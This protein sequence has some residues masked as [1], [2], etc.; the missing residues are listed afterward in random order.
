[1]GFEI[2]KCES[3]NFVLL[4]QDYFGYLEALEFYMNLKIGF[5][6]SAEKSLWNFDR[7]CTDSVDH[8]GNY[9]HLNNKK[10]PQPLQQMVLGKLLSNIQKNETGLLSYT[11]Q[12]NKFK[13]D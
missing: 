4:S 12:K 5:S 2:R 3:S 9:C 8:F 13:M 7:N 11:T 6:I 1:M 10:S